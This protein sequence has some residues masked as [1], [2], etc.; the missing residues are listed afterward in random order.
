MFALLFLWR[1]QGLAF[2]L[3]LDFH[4]ADPGLQLQQFQLCVAELLAARTI[5]LD[6][7]E[8][9]LLFQQLDL[10]MRPL[11]FPLELRDLFGFREWIG[12]SDVHKC[13]N[14]Y[15]TICY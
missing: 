6:P 7:L 5:L 3:R 15:N 12:R 9:Q 4:I 2:A 14:K 13:N 10:Q 1:R 11:Q 8:P